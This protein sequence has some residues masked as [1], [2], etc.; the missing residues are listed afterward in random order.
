MRSAFFRLCLPKFADVR[1]AQLLATG[2]GSCECF[3]GPLCDPVTL[4]L[5]DGCVNVQH[6]RIHVGAELGDDEG[7]PLHHQ[8]ADEMN[9]AA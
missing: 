1:V 6:E 4:L 9:V 7:H 8:A 5:G 2:L 3:L